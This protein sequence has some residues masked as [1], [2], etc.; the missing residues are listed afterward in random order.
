MLRSFEKYLKLIAGPTAGAVGGVGHVGG[1]GA[2]VSVLSFGPATTSH[3]IRH[4]VHVIGEP[5]PGMAHYR[6]PIDHDQCARDR[7]QWQTQLAHNS[8]GNRIRVAGVFR[9]LRFRSYCQLVLV[10][11][12]SV[13]II[14]R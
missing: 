5:T 1:G 10:Q 12:F 9:S 8:V 2:G 4:P 7:F 3:F 13:A 11:Y 6:H 14:T